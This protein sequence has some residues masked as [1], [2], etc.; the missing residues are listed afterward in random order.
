MQTAIY[1]TQHTTRATTTSPTPI[2]SDLQC[3][4]GNRV[5][6]SLRDHGLGARVATWSRQ[7]AI[8]ATQ[9]GTRS[10]TTSPTPV[11]SDPTAAVE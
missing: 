11:G 4:L 1:D 2:S 7:P 8:H 3:P 6:Q 10:T 5:S 9:H